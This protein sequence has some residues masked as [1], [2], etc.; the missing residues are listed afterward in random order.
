ML[1][2]VTLDQLRTLV[3]V[4]REGSFSAAARKLR[5][6]QSAVSQSMANLEQVLGVTVWDRTHRLPVL[7][8]HGRAI[9]AAAERV[10]DRADEL[11]HLADGL[12]GGLEPGVSLVVDALFPVPALVELCRGFA[13]AYP[14]VRL[15]V[16]TEVL[17]AVTSLVAD[18]TCNI[19]VAVPAAIGEDL[20]QSHLFNVRM[21]TVCAPSH[22][23]AARPRAVP[24]R[25]AAEH[26]QIVLG[27]RTNEGGPDHAVLSRQTWRVLELA[28]KHALLLGGLGWGNM[29][30]HA[31]V[32]DLRRGRLVRLD[33][34]AWG[35]S[36]TEV[37]LATVH[38]PDLATGPATRWLLGRMR[39]LCT[40]AVP[41]KRA[42]VT[43]RPRPR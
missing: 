32:D 5:R 6:V 29:P 9:L 11:H 24:S 1:D 12:V 35:R 10:C 17:G 23:L 26:V 34:E 18:G 22:P 2:A 28:T 19:G 14:S 30:D 31:V 33:L 21:I 16:R 25:V 20:V 4:A 3:T 42:A 36:P 40:G 41:K 39:E 38:K 37:G 8:G 15:G 13:R 7:T 43:A 27:E